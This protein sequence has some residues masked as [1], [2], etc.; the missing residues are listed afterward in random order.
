MRELKQ[1]GAKLIIVNLPEKKQ[2]PMAHYGKNETP[3]GY[4]VSSD[5]LGKNL[6]KKQKLEIIDIMPLFAKLPIEPY[7]FPH[8]GHMTPLG[9][10]LVALGI[11]DYL[12][13]TLIRQFEANSDKR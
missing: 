3:P 5:T 1:D 6:N 10:Q 2:K 11:K 9:L 13:P 7:Y 4:V 12:K 8:D